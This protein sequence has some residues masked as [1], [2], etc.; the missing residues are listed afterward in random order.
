MA[1]RTQLSDVSELRKKLGSQ[2]QYQLE[3]LDS[4]FTTASERKDVVES[5]LEVLVHNDEQRREEIAE[6]RQSVEQQKQIINLLRRQLNPT[7]N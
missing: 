7:Q 1:V 6:L 2:L 5:L 3:K 4:K